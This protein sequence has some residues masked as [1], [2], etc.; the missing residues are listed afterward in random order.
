MQEVDE[1]PGLR[2]RKKRARL[3]ALV[4][5]THRLAGRHGLEHVT[6]EAIC[7]EVGVSVRTFFNY[8][9]TKD[10]AVL[11]MSQWQL[12]T[13]ASDLFA[14]GGPTEDLM[15]DL[16]VLVASILDHPPLGPERMARAFEIA[17]RHPELL[18]RAYVQLQSHHDQVAGLVRRR[19]GP[20]VDD[21]LVHAVGALMM[22]LAHSTFVRWD[23]AGAQGDVREH[24]PTLVADLGT[25]LGAPLFAPV[26]APPSAPAPAPAEPATTR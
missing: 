24:L 22:V 15:A 23:A 16:Q 6:V 12:D 21:A 20:D 25:L 11:G 3:E 5:A 7:A 17:K 9:E 18:I 26:P 2:E 10:D 14:E 19:L 13:A 8:F 4:D 1:T